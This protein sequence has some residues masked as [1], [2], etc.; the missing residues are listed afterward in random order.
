MSRANF[1]ASGLS[2][3][4]T[5]VIKAAYDAEKHA[6][7]LTING[8]PYEGASKATRQAHANMAQDVILELES[9]LIHQYSADENEVRAL[10]ANARRK[11][12]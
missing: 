7:T 11:L 5:V 10:S 6:I 8:S 2:V 9:V 3:E 1:P 12:A 4:S